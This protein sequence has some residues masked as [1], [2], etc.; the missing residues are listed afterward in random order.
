MS[1]WREL[2]RERQRLFRQ[3]LKEAPTLED[4]DRDRLI[5]LGIRLGRPEMERLSEI[6]TRGLRGILRDVMTLRH[7]E[8]KGFPPPMTDIEERV[9][10][11]RDTRCLREPPCECRCGYVCGRACGL[12]LMECMGKHYKLDCDHKFDGAW[13]TFELPN[14]GGGGSV[15]CSTCGLTQLDHDMRCGP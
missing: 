2:A 1:D 14:G 6:T 3:A 11:L 10:A 13:E 15:T 4:H 9:E 8:G 12:P 7:L 5:R